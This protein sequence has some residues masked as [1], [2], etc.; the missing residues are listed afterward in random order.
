MNVNE[1][2]TNVLNYVIKSF[3]LCGLYLFAESLHFC[4]FKVNNRNTRIRYEICSKL[5]IKIS[6]WRHWR[7]SGIFIANFEN[8]SHLVLV[9]PLLSLGKQVPAGN[10]IV[11]CNLKMLSQLS[12]L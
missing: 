2:Y 1:G 12:S 8:I 3:H 10:F 7:R 4:M 6:E 9:F 11:F 5:T